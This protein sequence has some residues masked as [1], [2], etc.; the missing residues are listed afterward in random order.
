MLIKWTSKGLIFP[1][2]CKG[3]LSEFVIVKTGGASRDPE[4]DRIV[5]DSKGKFC[6]ALLLLPEYIEKLKAWM[7]LGCMT[8]N[9]MGNSFQVC[10]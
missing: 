6:G 2:P 4:T 9:G 8:H 5:W 1:N 10:K 3:E 7:L